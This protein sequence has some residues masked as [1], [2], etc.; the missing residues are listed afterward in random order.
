MAEQIPMTVKDTARDL[1]SGIKSRIPKN[2]PSVPKAASEKLQFAKHARGRDGGSLAPTQASTTGQG[3]EIEMTHVEGN[4]AETDGQIYS[5]S[6]EGAGE[7][8]EYNPE[9]AAGST[10]YEN[11]ALG[12]DGNVPQ[13]HGHVRSM[14]G[15]TVVGEGGEGG[16]DMITAWQAGWNVTNAIQ[17]I[18]H[19]IVFFSELLFYSEKLRK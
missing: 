16:H 15:S 5:P 7:G 2:L 12:Q 4:Y 17:V 6:Y 19:H 9:N 11:I 18:Y 13:Q 8:L 1:F 14:S 3:G 10:D